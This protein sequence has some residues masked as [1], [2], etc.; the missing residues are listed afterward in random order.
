MELRVR[1]I[2]D[3]SAFIRLPSRVCERL[4]GKAPKFPLPMK[5]KVIERGMRILVGIIREG[6]PYD[7]P[8]R[9]RESILG[10]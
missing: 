10:D 4:L 9:E 3:N 1:L 5:V 8:A 2:Y 7:I 6:V